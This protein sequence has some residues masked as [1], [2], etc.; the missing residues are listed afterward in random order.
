M[1]KKT[2]LIADDHWP[3]VDAYAKALTPL[4]WVDGM[5]RAENEKE[6]WAQLKARKP[7]LLLLDIQFGDANGVE[8][9]TLVRE[10][11]PNI[12]IVLFTG[13][14]EDKL[15]KKALLSNVDGFFLKKDSRHEFVDLLTKVISGQSEICKSPSSISVE[16]ELKKKE[17]AQKV[18]IAKVSLTKRQREI[19]KLYACKGLTVKE[20]AEE[21]SISPKTV[22][23]HRNEIYFRLGN[24]KNKLALHKAIIELGICEESS[25]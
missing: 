7:D 10:K 23:N 14:T 4:D 8:L 24:P 22:E 25:L 11:H 18:N 5:W 1:K 17:T 21:L 20:V 2:L 15:M 13:G 12:K 9:S 16:E 6:L 19:L 3:I